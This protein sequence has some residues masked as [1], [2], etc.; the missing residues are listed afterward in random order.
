MMKTS[1]AAAGLIACLCGLNPQTAAQT[2]AAPATQAK[3]LA[4]I[5]DT[6]TPLWIESLFLGADRNEE[7]TDS[8]FADI[9]RMHPASLF[10]L[11][12]LV[13]LGAYASAWDKI[14]RDIR[15]VRNAHIPVHAILGN[16]ELMFYSRTGEQYFSE[17]F[18]THRK[19][20]YCISVDS[21]AIVLLNSNF[22][23]L[24][25]GEQR[26]QEQWYSHALDS[27]EQNPGTTVIVVCCHHSPFTNSMVVTSSEAVREKFV[28]PFLRIS[29]CLLFLSGHAHTFERF[30]EQ[31]KD[32]VVIGGGGGSRH[33]VLTGAEQNW[34]DISPQQKPIFHYITLE[35]QGTSLH[36][37]VRQLRGDFR[38]VDGGYAFDISSTLPVGD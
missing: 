13:S 15:A 6:Q 23:K 24:N 5:A 2:T 27:L 20:G 25:E 31:G 34:K 9:V 17:A 1:I 10:M 16:H 35:R 8:L 22:D 38:G 21:V 7:A 19:T 37:N 26:E 33:Q 29:K 28:P 11:G 14:D 36:I 18:P 30:K 12:D 4:F 32:F 3:P